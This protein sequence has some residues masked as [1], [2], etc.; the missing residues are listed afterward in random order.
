MR[1]LVLISAS[2]SPRPLAMATRIRMFVAPGPKELRSRPITS[3]SPGASPGSST[4]ESNSKEGGGGAE[5]R[6]DAGG[7]SEAAGKTAPLGALQPAMAITVN[8]AIELARTV[9]TRVSAGT[10][11]NYSLKVSSK[12]RSNPKGSEE[13]KPAPSPI[14]HNA[15]DPESKQSESNPWPTVS[16]KETN[17]A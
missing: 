4:I 2:C 7:V 11:G 1:G 15:V 9:T 12:P 3:Q 17:P 5:T 16:S 10:A 14:W 6:A 8:K 13:P